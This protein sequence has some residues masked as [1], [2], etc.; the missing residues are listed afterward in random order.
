[1]DH[2]LL[3]KF[4]RKGRL[5]LAPALELD[6]GICHIAD[7]PNA[8]PLKAFPPPSRNYGDNPPSGAPKICN[9]RVNKH[10]Q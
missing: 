10:G 3:E 2:L 9:R 1:M 7:M 6:N 4:I 5:Q 8:A